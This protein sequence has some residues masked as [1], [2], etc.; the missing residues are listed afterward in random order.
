MVPPVCTETT[1]YGALVDCRLRIT[2]PL[3]TSRLIK[4]LSL[5]SLVAIIRT[6]IWLFTI[7]TLSGIEPG[8]IH[9][10]FALEMVKVNWVPTLPSTLKPVEG[11]TGGVLPTNPPKP[12]RLLLQAAAATQSIA[13]SDRSMVRAIV[14]R[15]ESRIRMILCT[16]IRAAAGLSCHT[17]PGRLRCR[18]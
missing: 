2:P 9:D 8:T 14:L 11:G 1:P 4:L 6:G 12:P 15:T 18:R 7:H 13:A 3:S 17:D 5:A 16:I 10:E